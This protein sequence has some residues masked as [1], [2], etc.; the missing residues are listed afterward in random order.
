MSDERIKVLEE[1]K[2]HA[3]EDIALG[4]YIER[5]V[6]EYNRPLPARSKHVLSVDQLQT[7]IDAGHALLQEVD[8]ELTAL[9]QTRQTAQ[10]QQAGVWTPP[11]TDGV[12]KAAE[13]ARRNLAK[14]AAESEAAVLSAGAR[15]RRAVQEVYEAESEAGQRSRFDIIMGQ[16]RNRFNRAAR[17]ALERDI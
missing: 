1:Q 16:H 4:R 8:P 12:R 10:L 13:D 9:Y 3:Q 17:E 11:A 15:L 7:R 6:D 14:V 2:R 5:P